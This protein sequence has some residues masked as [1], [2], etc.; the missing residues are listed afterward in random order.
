MLT[1][2]TT[3][4]GLV[5]LM[6][7]KSLQSQF[8]IPMAVSLAFGVMFATVV[9]L[10]LIPCAQLAAHDVVWAWSIALPG[11]PSAH[12]SRTT[13]RPSKKSLP[14]G[15][16]FGIHFKDYLQAYEAK[17]SVPVELFM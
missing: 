11:K 7:D 14:T 3:F 6:M 9:T 4:V 13:R 10:F 17:R 5:P 16:N 15:P 2:V 12:R 1:F 8:L